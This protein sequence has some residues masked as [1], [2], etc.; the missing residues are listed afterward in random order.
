[1][2]YYPKPEVDNNLR[3]LHN[4]SYENRNSITVLAFIQNIS[5]FLT[6]LSS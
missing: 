5:M 6:S 4:S 2:G 3:D 1:M